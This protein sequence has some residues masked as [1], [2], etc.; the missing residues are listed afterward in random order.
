MVNLVPIGWKNGQPQRLSAGEKISSTFLEL[1]E[2]GASENVL[3]N[4]TQSSHG[5]SVGSQIRPTS[6]GWVAAQGNTVANATNVWTVIAVDG[7]DVTACKIGRVN[8]PSHGLGSNNTLLYLSPTSAGGLT[9][10]KPVGTNSNFLGFFLPVIFIEDANTIHVLGKSY[11]EETNLL[12]RHVVSGT[13]QSITFSG[14]SLNA[15]KSKLRFEMRL[16]FGFDEGDLFWAVPNSTTE[17]TRRELFNSGSNLERTISRTAN[18]IYLNYAGTPS[19]YLTAEWRNVETFYH[20]ESTLKFDNAL[21][22]KY[23]QTFNLS[24]GSDITQIG[25]GYTGNFTTGTEVEVYSD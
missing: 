10:T 12:A 4:F 13:P 23:F 14:F 2:S 5:F 9:S 8:I 7:N 1:P 16:K 15:L 22:F 21:F 24:S 6:S 3:R 19:V 17:T 20:I 25:L 11:P 18:L